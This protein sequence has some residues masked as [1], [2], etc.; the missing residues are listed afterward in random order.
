VTPSSDPGP[1]IRPT[2]VSPALNA[3]P[4]NALA[5]TLTVIIAGADGRWAWPCGIAQRAS[6][7][8]LVTERLPPVRFRVRMHR[9]F[10]RS[11]SA[12]ARSRA[13]VHTVLIVALS[14]SA[15]GQSRP[16]PGPADFGQWETLAP[17][18]TRGGL[19]PDGAWLVYAINRS[20]RNNELRAVR[21]ADRTTRVAA[22]GTQPVFSG[23]SR[24]LA[25]GIGRSEAQEEKLR[26][27]KKPVHRQLGLLNLSSLE[28]ATIDDIESF[29]FDSSG[30]YLAMRRYAAEKPAREGPAA[31]SEESDDPPPATLIVRT[32]ATGRDMTFGNVSEYAWQNTAPGAGSLLACAIAT[33]DKT[34]NGIQL[35]DPQN[36]ALRVLDSG[37]TVYSG[38]AWRKDALSLAAL[39][40]KTDPRHRDPTQVLLAWPD[41]SRA[42]LAPQIFD[43]AIGPGVP[44]GMRT[45][46]YRKPTWSRDGRLVFVGLST[47]AAAPDA[48][49][50][51]SSGTRDR[52]SSSA[53]AET[54]GADGDDEEPPGVD[55]WHPRDVDVLPKQKI[56][57]RA[58]RRRTL[59]AAWHVEPNRLVQLSTD[60]RESVEPIQR[61]PNAAYVA[62]WSPY[63]MDRSIGRG[64]ADVS[65]VDVTSGVRTK[66]KDRID[67][68]YLGVSPSGRYLL[69][70][71]AD[72]YWTIDL[73]T[74]ATVNITRG[75]AASF[76]NR[77]SDATVRQKP[78]FGVAGWTK[79][80][81]AVLLYDQ[82]DIW[83]VAPDGSRATKLTDGAADQI[84]HR[85]VRLDPDE[86][87][88]DA[89]KPL[90]VSLFGMWTKKSGYARLGPGDAKDTHLLLMDKS[91]G[92]LARARNADVYG[93]VTQAFDDSPDYFV[94]GP[95]LGEAK[96]ATETNP[97]Q[98]N[99]AWGRAELIEYKSDRG[100]RL[101][102]ALAYPANYDPAKKYPMVVYVYEKRSDALHQYV[103]PSE[104]DYY[105]ATAFTSAGY[106]FLQPDIVFRPREPGLSVVEC[107]GPAVKKVVQMGLVD[108]KRVGVVGHSWGGFDTTFLATHTDIF[109]AAVAGAPI[110]DLVSNYGNHH[111]S[112][113]IAETDHIETGQ[114]RME[115]PL[116][117]DLQAYIRNSAVFG[118]QTMKTPL[119]I[120]V[121]D[122]DGTVFWHQGV[123]LYNIARRARKDVV[124]LVY[125][126]EDHGL[127]KR[128]NQVDYHRRILAWF[129]HY[130][131]GEAAAPWITDGVRFLDREEELKR[132]KTRKPTSD[133]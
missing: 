80:D 60:P 32:L 13:L 96:A 9:I 30:L 120:E 67:D 16:A 78:P 101:Q 110:T 12:M 23:D 109:A 29:A 42:Q 121:G 93:Y 99:Y 3:L 92:R 34:G 79:N 98:R 66:L 38:L 71:D 81:A 72:H 130:L 84:Q 25:Y 70:F 8:P 4:V 132:L 95:N 14:I 43:P 76:T 56:G 119:L 45:S 73:D 94:G 64:A 1:E 82:F 59:L 107:V 52:S 74:K 105:N 90:Y 5:Y 113:G 126:G 111:W 104:R 10:P 108:P 117:E 2:P 54:P 62:S 18:G 22:F 33:D 40:A 26:K 20:N 35:F 133:Q 100:E 102:G 31:A 48:E 36:G 124:L 87:F 28:T 51:A 128:P 122:S 41:V 77:E 57:A 6:E 103:S 49:S 88:I 116:Y 106:L 58:D 68:R 27:E 15:R 61:R 47:W 89:D 50:T 83:Q 53:R 125:A 44:A 86:E 24:W 131:K 55:V 85:Y 112:S 46:P 21:L 118:V 69:Y 129:G 7:R 63:A 97:F 127:R 114:Q 17:A 11:L 19:S 115:V 91:V 75:V 37:A 65:L 123:E 39:K